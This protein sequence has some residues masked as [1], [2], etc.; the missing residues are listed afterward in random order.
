MEFIYS[1]IFHNSH[2]NSSASSSH[3]HHLNQAIHLRDF[4]NVTEENGEV[5][6]DSKLYCSLLSGLPNELNFAFNVAT[7][8]TNCQR[9]NWTNDYKFINV[10]IESVKSYCCICDYIIEELNFGSD[11]INEEDEILKLEKVIASSFV[12]NTN[13]FDITN[14]DSIKTD[15]FGLTNL[16]KK[17]NI[18]FVERRCHCYLKFWHQLCLNEDLLNIIF[19]DSFDEINFNNSFYKDVSHRL[20]QKVERKIALIADII[21]NISFTYDQNNKN[22]V[23]MTP[24]LKFLTLLFFSDNVKYVN[25]SLDILSNIAPILSYSLSKPHENQYVCLLEILF[26]KLTNIALTS[27]NIHETTKSFEIMARYL[28]STNNEAN[29]LLEKF[30]QKEKVKKNL[31]IFFQLF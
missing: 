20:F 13:Y 14:N 29:I 22:K 30:L 26:K 23:K 16:K 24:L 5:H 28:S 27:F 1:A 10:L 17:N 18:N 2:S 7:I 15:H 9:F 4:H 12:N 31:N 11:T 25:I 8:L 21:R 3:H 19:S 6:N